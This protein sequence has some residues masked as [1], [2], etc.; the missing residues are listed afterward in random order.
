MR[1]RPYISEIHYY[2]RE[3]AEQKWF[4]KVLGGWDGEHNVEG[5]GAGCCKSIAFSRAKKLFKSRVSEG[6][7]LSTLAA[8]LLRPLGGRRK[9]E[10]AREAKEENT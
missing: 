4:C 3:S 8:F 6:T 7:F 10:D 1:N 2:Y 5:K 9:G